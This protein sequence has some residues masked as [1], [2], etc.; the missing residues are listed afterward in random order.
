M[1]QHGARNFDE[2]EDHLAMVRD[3]VG[4][5]KGEI[6][7]AVVEHVEVR[8][9]CNL[10]SSLRSSTY[11][12]GTV[13]PNIERFVT[14][15]HNVNHPSMAHTSVS[16]IMSQV[17]TLQDQP[18]CLEV[19]YALRRWCGQPHPKDPDMCPGALE[20]CE[21]HLQTPAE[22][23][24]WVG[25]YCLDSSDPHRL[26]ALKEGE[27]PR[28]ARHSSIMGGVAYV[29]YVTRSSHDRSTLVTRS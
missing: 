12:K 5:S 21:A 10:L 9:K 2:D 13:N 22:A 19:K 14:F 6:S 18:N 23:A 26:M 16:E 25:L 24:S 29:R 20:R 3:I 1:V 11:V 27:R 17:K 4:K 8:S 28:K 15:L 7:G